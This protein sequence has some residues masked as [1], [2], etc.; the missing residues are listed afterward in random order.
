MR[1]L[2]GCPRFSVQRR[3]P[4]ASDVDNENAVKP[5]VGVRCRVQKTVLALYGVR[6]ALGGSWRGFQ[7]RFQEGGSGRRG[8]G[9]L[10]GFVWFGV[11]WIEG[12]E[13]LDGFEA[14]T[15]WEFRVCETRK[16]KH[17][18]YSLRPERL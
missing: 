13:G 6:R 8:S 15:V 14:L 7:E 16:K 4:Q 9:C 10:R 18:F 5:K 1:R 3:Q 17:V 2:W 11:I 12:F